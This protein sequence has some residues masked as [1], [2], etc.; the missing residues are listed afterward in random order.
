M[1]EKKWIVDNYQLV[2]RLEETVFG[3]PMRWVT[4]VPS[5][6]SGAIR[7]YRS[8]KNTIRSHP[9]ITVSLGGAGIGAVHLAT[10]RLVPWIVDQA[11]ILSMIAAGSA[12]ALGLVDRQIDP[13]PE[14]QVR[15]TFAGLDDLWSQAYRKAFREDPD[16]DTVDRFVRLARNPN[17]IVDDIARSADPESEAKRLGVVVSLAADLLAT[18]GRKN[19]LREVDPAG[20][21]RSVLGEK[22]WQP[23]DEAAL[24]IVRT[25]HRFNEVMKFLKGNK[26][27][28]DEPAIDRLE[29]LLRKPD[30]QL[31]V[32]LPAAFPVHHFGTQMS[33]G[34]VRVVGVPGNSAFSYLGL[35]DPSGKPYVFFQDGSGAYCGS[36]QLS[37][38][39]VVNGPTGREPSKDQKG[40][41][42]LYLAT[43]GDGAFVRMNGAAV[44]IVYRPVDPERI[45]PITNGRIVLLEQG[46]S[47]R[48][49]SA[50]RWV[51][52]EL[53]ENVPVTDMDMLVRWVRDG[54]APRSAV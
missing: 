48:A 6:S 33:R 36:N 27:A 38:L 39:V 22:A 1:A 51:N 42:A 43:I 8:V 4:Y 23:A 28:G 35:H 18:W 7:L 53:V 31:R 46:P 54:L 5:E 50:R 13:H 17:Y 19:S 16:R 30:L 49:P 15:Q 24:E 2:G 26:D 29:D 41:V 21:L 12:T 32:H 3:R 44:G 20:I 9:W 45:G 47:P 37:G 40:G 52:G 11:E 25:N 10:E 14:T 34:S